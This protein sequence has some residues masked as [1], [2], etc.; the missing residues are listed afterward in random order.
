MSDSDKKKEVVENN[1]PAKAEKEKDQPQQQRQEEKKNTFKELLPTIARMVFFFMLYKFMSQMAAN[2]DLYLYLSEN[3]IFKEFRNENKLLWKINDIKFKDWNESYT[4]DFE[5]EL[6][7]SVLNNGTYYLHA[8]FVLNGYSP[9]PSSPN[10]DR[11]KL[12]I[13]RNKKKVVIKKKLFSK[14]DEEKTEVIE[15]PKETEEDK[16]LIISYWYPELIVNYLPDTH[17]IDLRQLQPDMY[18]GI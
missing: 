10:F 9:D 4:K 16:D 14:D 17:M 13:I 18:R 11:K 1:Q 5:I 8:F 7:D 2:K 6:P 12:L 3:E 15:K